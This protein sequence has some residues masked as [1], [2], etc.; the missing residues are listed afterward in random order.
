MSFYLDIGEAELW[1][2][3]VLIK[4]DFFIQTLGKLYLAGSGPLTS[5]G[6]FSDGTLAV[7]SFNSGVLVT[8][9]DP[10]PDWTNQALV[11]TSNY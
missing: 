8:K 3:I 6:P 1:R 9:F 7:S 2:E 5:V 11:L 4:T 10:N